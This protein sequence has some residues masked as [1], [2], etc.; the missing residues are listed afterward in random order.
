[1]LV[2]V[3]EFSVALLPAGWLVVFVLCVALLLVAESGPCALLTPLL[4]VGS[5][6]R[7]ARFVDE[8]AVLA[9]LLNYAKVTGP[10]RLSRQETVCAADEC[11][12]PETLV[13]GF[14]SPAR[15][16]MPAV[17][18]ALVLF[19][20]RLGSSKSFLAPELATVTGA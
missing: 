2:L 8:E 7:V 9:F 12:V 1:M 11:C 14:P 16:N 10:A 3:S 6:S 20:A 17:S 5:S 13:G 15:L 18:L 4:V 19:F